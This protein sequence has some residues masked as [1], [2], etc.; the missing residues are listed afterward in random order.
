MDL[1]AKCMAWLNPDFYR[2]TQEWQYKNIK[3]RII[4]E[5][6]LQTKEGVIPND[7]KLNYI[8]GKLEFI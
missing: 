7:Y 6:L 8:N 2:I 3:R 4:I 1:R 5:Q